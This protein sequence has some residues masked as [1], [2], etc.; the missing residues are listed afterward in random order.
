MNFPGKFLSATLLGLAVVLPVVLPVTTFAREPI[1]PIPQLFDYDREKA[2][3]GKRLFMDKRFSS[4]GTVS[5]ATC[6][7]LEKG[8]VDNMKFSLGVQNQKGNMN[9][10]TVLNSRFNFRQFWNGRAEDLKEQAAGPIHNP[11]E[12]GLDDEKVMNIVLSDK[13]YQAGFKKFLDR[14]PTFDDVLDAIAEFE[15]AL[16]TPDSKFDR[17]LRGETV[18]SEE[19]RRGYLAFKQLGC[20]SCHNGVNVGGNSFQYFGAVNPVQEDPNASD[21]Y[22]VTRDPFDRSRYKVPTLRNIELTYPYFHDGSA[23][24]LNEAVSMMAHHNLGFDLTEE[25]VNDIVA[26]LKTLTGVMPEI[27]R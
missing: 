16:V 4:D 1:E 12:M 15:K 25:E 10:P 23:S 18:L 26:F 9:A 3:V 7:D 22:Q 27:L 24:T 17:Y 14:E 20:V 2:L 19:E 6:H 13:D 8:G 11:V 5:C 21:R